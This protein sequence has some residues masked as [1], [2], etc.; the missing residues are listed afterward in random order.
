MSDMRLHSVNWQDGM[1]I[2]QAHLKDQEDYFE[3]LVR[4]YAQSPADNFGL[5]R[6]PGDAEDTLSLDISVA[7]GRL[8][9]EL[10]RC[11]AL[12]PGGHF[13]DV[14]KA[15][16]NRVRAETDA[17]NGELAVY[18]SVNTENKR[19]V[20]EPD[21]KVASAISPIGFAR[22]VFLA[23]PI[24]KNITPIANLSTVWERSTN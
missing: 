13:V 8:R 23:N 15:S 1:L 11:R 2:S 7:G 17:T 16:Q 3:N 6:S 4:W 21:P 24:M 20:G 18:L 10:A 22:R 19:E 12:T 5:A 9:V 14:N